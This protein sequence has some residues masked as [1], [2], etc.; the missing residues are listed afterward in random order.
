[1][2]DEKKYLDENGLEYLKT[3]LD[4]TYANKDEG[5]SGNYEDLSNKPT[6]LSQFTNDEGF[7]NETQV[8]NLINKKVSSVMRYKGT[9]DRYVDLPSN[10]E[11]GDTYNVT[12]ASDYNKA[13]DNV[14]WNGTEWDVLSGA[15]DL[16]SYWSKSELRAI[17]NEEVEALFGNTS[18]GDA[19]FPEFP[20]G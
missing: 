7:Q 9:V 19:E 12:Y 18:G 11:I 4:D 16:S 3:V 6:K 8:N 20:I 15:I 2:S 1:M 13:G 17:T 5:F 10:A 14:A